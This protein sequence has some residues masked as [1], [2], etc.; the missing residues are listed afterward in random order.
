[1]KLVCVCV[2]CTVCVIRPDI[3]S[4]RVGKKINIVL[5]KVLECGVVHVYL[6][7]VSHL[8]GFKDK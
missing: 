8:E 5:V 7:V 6:Y 1:M 2:V 3:T 4:A